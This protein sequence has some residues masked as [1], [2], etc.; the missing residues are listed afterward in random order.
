MP[1][2][3]DP[4]P[5]R[6]RAFSGHAFAFLAIA[7]AYVVTAQIGLLLPSVG[8]S[9]CPIWP[10]AGV[11]VAVLLRGGWR[12]VPAV[13]AGALVV[14]LGLVSWWAAVGVAAG[15]T[16]ASVAAVVLLRRLGFRP[17]FESQWDVA[18]FVLV[19]AFGGMLLSATNGVFW[20]ALDG[21][22]RWQRVADAWWV[23]WLGDALGVLVFGTPL[24]AFTFPKPGT[25]TRRTAV[26]VAVA[27]AACTVVGVLC[28]GPVFGDTARRYPLVLFP[29]LLIIAATVRY[30]LAVGSAAGALVA[31]VA[32]WTTA[33][34]AGAF[35]RAD[36]H[37]SLLM[38]WSYLGGLSVVVLA[39]A[40]VSAG[41]A[42]AERWLAASEATY[43][44]L[45]EDNPAM[46][47]R[48]APDGLLTFAN[49]TYFQAV[50]TSAAAAVGRPF[51]AGCAPEDR[52]K[53]AAILTGL[54]PGGEP[55]EVELLAPGG[56]LRWHKWQVRAVGP[57]GGPAGGYQ[58]VGLDVTDRR[59]AED[60]RRAVEEQMFHAQKLESLGVMA[61]GVAHDFNNILTGILGFAELAAEDLP[62]DSPARAHLTRVGESA[63]RAAELTRHLLAYAGKGKMFPR[64]LDPNVAVR[65]TAE[66][67][68]V[69]IPKKVTLKFDLA[70]DLSWVVADETQFRQVLMNLI[71]N[72]GEAIGDRT[73][74][75]TV[76][77]DETDV[78]RDDLDLLGSTVRGGL[79]PGRYVRVRVADTGCGMDEATLAKIFEPFFT[80]KFTG[81][82]LGLAAVQGIARAHHGF[83]R[84]VSEPGRGSE[85]TVLLPATDPPVPADVPDSSTRDREPAAGR[86][87]A[88][89]I[90]DEDAVRS[91]TGKML[92]MLGWDVLEAEDG[93]AGLALFR[94]HYDA[95]AVVVLDLSMPEMDGRETL[96][97]LRQVRPE[98][99]VVLSTGYTPDAAPVVANTRV[100]LKPFR[101]ADL[102]RA[103]NRVLSSIDAAVPVGSGR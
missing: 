72:A 28:V 26:E 29:T 88:L 30:G 5:A 92:G 101:F 95:I 75:V 32:V 15:N 89:V 14:H 66:L 11:A 85:F 94:A 20:L 68:A 86:R 4:P 79:A 51:L 27:L 63:R 96:A 60:E 43:R 1:K 13:F 23:W 80:T 73:G 21:A 2:I 39:L 65:E 52:T 18:K 35:A 90:D 40:A 64:P 69:S 47:C 8:S 93:R 57:V 70:D 98:V 10:P 19:G 54:R 24:L 3:S 59:R 41:R 22:M 9:V 102:K 67:V 49:A 74:T 31:A 103:V 25:L 82:G 58:A 99:P 16:L 83:V 87:V 53:L 46:I 77:T 55:V 45:I 36:E 44:G 12:F 34:G 76:R 62:P 56:R 6:D 48:L 100:L 7:T 71:I 97:A 61:G 50:R 84:V 33:T 42:R 78:V 38:L 17:T 91:A 37:A 81:R